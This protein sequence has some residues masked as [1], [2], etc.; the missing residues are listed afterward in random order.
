MNKQ[1]LA[2]KIWE[3]A[4][5]MRSKIE[6]N[7][8]KDYIL[9]FIFYK[10]L[11]DKEE[12]WLYQRDY[13]ADSI[14]E[15]VNE[16]ADDQ[17]S[18][19]SSAQQSLGYF[20]A[21]KD[22]FSTWI[23]MGSDFSVDNVRTGLSSF[24]RLISPSHKKVFEGIFN[25]LETGLSKLGENTKS[26]T[27]AVS[28]LIQLINE[29]PMSGKQDYDVLGFIYEYLISN[30]A[31]NAGKKAGEFYT[32]HEVS[33]LMSE[34]VADHLQGRSEIKIYD[35]TSGSGSLLINIGKTAAKYMDDANR[36]RYYAQELKANTYNLTR[37]N[38]VMRGILPDNILT[39]NGDTLEE[40]WPYFDESDPQGTYEPLYVDAVVSNPPY[41][42]RW[43]PNGKENDARYARYGLAPK[44]KAD[45]AFLLH[46]LYHL[47]PDGIMTIVLPHG[48]L[49]R[50]GEEGAI[51]KNLIEQ[52]NIDAIIGLPANIFFGTG[53]PTIIMVLRQ[54]REN[55]DVL[56]IDA[57]KGF[58]KEGKNNK[59]RA[60]DIRRII[61]TVK[62]RKTVTK[63]SRLVPRQEIRDNDYNLNIPRYVDSSEEAES[64]DIYASMFGGIPKPELEGLKRYWDVFPSLQ[65]EL[66]EGDGEYLSLKTED[67]KKVIHE[68][69][70]VKTF[71]EGYQ[72]AFA[73]FDD[74]MDETLIDAAESLSIPKTEEH[75]ASD[76][77]AR[78][79]QVPLIDPYQAY[80]I[81][82]G[83]FA[84]VSGDLEL[85]QAE[86]MQAVKQVDPNMVIK[87]KD[88]KDHEVQ[89]G[90]KGHILPFELVQQVCISDQVNALKEKQDQLSE[91]P[92]SYEELLDGLSEDDKETISDAL[93]DTNDGFV[94][95]N[96]KSM[97]KTLKADGAAEAQ[98]IE[99]LQS[100]D[101]LNTREKKLKSEIKQESEALHLATK[102]TIEHLTD[103]QVRML[104]HDKW[105]QPV[106]DGILALST[107]MLNTFIKK[108]EELSKKY[109]VTMSDLEAEIQETEKS[110]A[111]MLSDLVGSEEDMAGIHELQKLLG[112]NLHE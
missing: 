56:I 87:K 5:R 75:I 18:S 40:D 86:G 100:A 2:A 85:I 73:D 104:L 33:L 30:F 15:Y 25:T 103:A 11:S 59:L 27:K 88:G 3:S 22:L 41:S 97:I 48:V 55:T 44:S 54:K 8:Y 78:F 57:S 21:Y 81:F 36:I 34:I 63:Y 110:L 84:T 26:Q 4:N 38:L 93:N 49:F 64:Y 13:D 112:G 47:K 72:Q 42:Q 99:V 92:S 69:L 60:S 24:N 31:A 61:D 65:N 106:E 66:F 90:W 14:R 52:N 89:E 80:E 95:K 17:Y 83:A 37:M 105:I 29:I 94:F 62:Q 9:G 111:S 53:I 108:I 20:I 77:F 23:H 1:Q 32:P 74:V 96:I 43:M 68:N 45:Y 101:R 102:D 71:I 10:Y 70:D 76:I 91:I 82:E 51:R 35:P 46:D 28:D 16:E 109:A 67:I 12:Q 50:G 7:E 79:Y 6:A 107:D 19:K 98:L 58:A 39:R